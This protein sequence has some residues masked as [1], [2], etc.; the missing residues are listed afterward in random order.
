MAKDII[1]QFHLGKVK[2]HKFKLPIIMFQ[3]LTKPEFKLFNQWCLG[4]KELTILWLSIKYYSPI[5][6][7]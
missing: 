4:Y 2:R 5:Q 7:K 1:I 3:F 6:N